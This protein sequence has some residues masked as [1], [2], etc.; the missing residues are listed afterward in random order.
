MYSECPYCNQP[1]HRRRHRYAT[2]DALADVN[3]PES[4]RLDTDCDDDDVLDGHEAA[5]CILNTDCDNDTV[6]DGT[7]VDM[8]R[9]TD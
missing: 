3:E 1:F 5:G 2:A 7:D 4:C 8:R 9:P 6:L